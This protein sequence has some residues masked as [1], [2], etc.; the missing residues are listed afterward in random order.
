VGVLFEHDGGE[1]AEALAE[2]GGQVQV[3]LHAR[4]AGIGQDRTAAERAGAE[5]HASLEDA[6]DLFL[7]QGLGEHAVAVGSG[8]FLVGEAVGVEELLD[9]ARREAG[10][11][12]GAGH[13]VVLVV[14][15]ARLVLDL[16]P[17]VE[18]GAER[19]AGVARGGLDPDVV[20]EP[21]AQDLAVGDAVEGDAAG[22][23]EVLL[24]RDRAGE[25]GH[26]QHDLFG[27][28]LDRAGQ[29]HLAQGDVRLG[30]A[31][32]AAEQAGEAVVGHLQIV[33]I[34]EI[35]IRCCLIWS[36]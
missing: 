25:A 7:A 17:D 8:H 14:G 30:L 29:V 34:T 24:A 20:E 13:L 9:L 35:S 1:G 23:A 4:T 26:L 5:L 2:L 19:A 36:V 22:Q 12:Q 6:D 28:V 21:G 10:P 27:D 32:L 16:V 15:L 3:R 18:G 31:P 33:E 11:E